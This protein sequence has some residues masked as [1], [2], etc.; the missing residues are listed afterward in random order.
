MMSASMW[1]GAAL[2]YTRMLATAAALLK[3]RLLWKRTPKF[4]ANFGRMRAL[5]GTLVEILFA[6]LFLILIVMV[7]MKANEIGW[8]AVLISAGG[9]IRF[10]LSFLAAPLMA[11][12]SANSEVETLK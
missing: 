8:L 7:I 11:L 5:G 2:T 9:L 1:A 6:A 12:I 3:I 10:F 4:S